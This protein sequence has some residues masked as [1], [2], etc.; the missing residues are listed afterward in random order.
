MSQFLGHGGHASYTQVP[1][2]AQ[3]GMPKYDL[4]SDPLL[5]IVTFQEMTIKH[6]MYTWKVPFLY[7]ERVCCSFFSVLKFAMEDFL[8]RIKCCKYFSPEGVFHY[9]QKLTRVPLYFSGQPKCIHHQ[10]FAFV[11]FL[12][13]P[14]FFPLILFTMGKLNVHD[15]FLDIILSLLHNCS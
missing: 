4:S 14:N 1:L 15:H 11:F 6:L 3:T 13:P 8:Y 2:I 10:N 7:T 9:E 12:S 5:L